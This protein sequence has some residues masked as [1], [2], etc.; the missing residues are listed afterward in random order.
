MLGMLD[1]KARQPRQTAARRFGSPMG[2]AR[3]GKNHLPQ[4]SVGASCSRAAYL[5]PNQ[6]LR[7]P[8]PSRASTL[9]LG[10]RLHH[11]LPFPFGPLAPSLPSPSSRSLA[12]SLCSL[13]SLQLSAERVLRSSSV[14]AMPPSLPSPPSHRRTSRLRSDD[15]GSRRPVVYRVS[16]TE[17]RSTMNAALV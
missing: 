7:A 3:G 12:R 6:P 16:R 4:R 15:R 2:L 1:E 11:I 8:C 5:P 9:F 17:Q 10:S 14:P 13:P